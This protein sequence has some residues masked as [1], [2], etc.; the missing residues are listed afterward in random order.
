MMIQVKGVTLTMDTWRDKKRL[1]ALRGVCVCARACVR[2]RLRMGVYK[3]EHVHTH[4]HG[5]SAANH[6][7]DHFVIQYI[8]TDQIVW[9]CVC[10]HVCVCVCR[11][12]ARRLPDAHGL[13][14]A[15][16]WHLF[17]WPFPGTRPTHQ[18]QVWVALALMVMVVFVVVELDLWIHLVYLLCVSIITGSVGRCWRDWS[19]ARNK[20]A[21]E[22]SELQQAWE[23]KEE[24][25]W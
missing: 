15:A 16:A 21:G 19:G 17:F 14:W 13:E 11:S 25:C 2:V 24:G 22:A 3:L 23:R 4:T 6:H 9:L 7:F 8:N 5:E 12:S 10:A 1:A 18:V 20:E